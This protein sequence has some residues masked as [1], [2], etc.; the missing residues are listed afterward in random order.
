MAGF[1]TRHINE[2]VKAKISN[3]IKTTNWQYLEQ[4]NTND[5]FIAFTNKL[6]DIINNE[7][8][9]KTV[10]IPAS[11]IIRDPWITTGLI[12]SSRKLNKLYKMKIGKDNS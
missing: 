12:T 6:N 11:R 4:L 3:T 5:A 7:V 10:I 8:Q 2:E 1:T 9:E